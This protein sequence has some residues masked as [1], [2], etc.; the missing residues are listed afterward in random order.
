MTTQTKS[1]PTAPGNAVRFRVR[2][3]HIPSADDVL[4][5]LFGD[6]ELAGQVVATS[7]EAY[8]AVQIPGLERLVVVPTARLR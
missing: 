7:G 3:I 1:Q 5:E 4:A 8:V 6:Q 2:D